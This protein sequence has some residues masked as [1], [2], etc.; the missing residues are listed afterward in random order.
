LAR[1]TTEITNKSSDNAERV[2]IHSV[3]KTT[4]ITKKSSDDAKRVE[5][6]SAGKTT[7]ITNR[8]SDGTERVEI[9]S[10]AKTTEITNKSSECTMTN[11]ATRTSIH[12]SDQAM[13]KRGNRT[14][15]MSIIPPVT[16]EIQ[17]GRKHKEI[18]ASHMGPETVETQLRGG[19]NEKITSKGVVE[20]EETNRTDCFGWIY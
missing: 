7:E 6:Q 4:Q 9:Q 10:V 16:I 12:E 19:I 8:S 3:G 17:P 18:P 20:H 13:R 11:Y 2:E 1:K 5:I 15:D 14:S